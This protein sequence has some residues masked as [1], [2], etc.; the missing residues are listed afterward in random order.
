M[1]VPPFILL[2]KK[3]DVFV[4]TDVFTNFI[5]KFFRFFVFVWISGFIQISV[6]FLTPSVVYTNILEQKR[7]ARQA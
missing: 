5:F 2:K 1:V 6:L 4:F 3:F 7:I